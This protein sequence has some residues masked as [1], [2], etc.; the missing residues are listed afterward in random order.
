MLARL[1]GRSSEPRSA[2]A[3]SEPADLVAEH[4]RPRAGAC[5]GAST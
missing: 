5:G 3:A 1:F 4:A 2:F